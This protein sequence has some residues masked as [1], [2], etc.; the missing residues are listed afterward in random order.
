VKEL[1]KD[2]PH[3]AGVMFTIPV[4]EIHRLSNK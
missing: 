2:A 4:G 3:W 1:L